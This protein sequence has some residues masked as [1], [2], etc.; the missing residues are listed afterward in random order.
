LTRNTATD[1]EGENTTHS[2][3]QIFEKRVIFCNSCG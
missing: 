1:R 2:S 3:E